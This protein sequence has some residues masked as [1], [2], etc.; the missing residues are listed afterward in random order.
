MVEIGK[1][2][3]WLLSMPSKYA[4]WVIPGAGFAG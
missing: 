3:N 4:P 1:S 2:N